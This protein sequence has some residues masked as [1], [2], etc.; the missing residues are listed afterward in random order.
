MIASFLGRL[1]YNVFSRMI[2][3]F[4]GTSLTLI[5]IQG[6]DYN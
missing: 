5:L 3:F 6:E 2:D 4:L 1:A